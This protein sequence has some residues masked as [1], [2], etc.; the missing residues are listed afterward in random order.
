MNAQTDEDE[1]DED[2]SG[3]EWPAVQTNRK[4]SGRFVLIKRS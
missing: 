1:D 2:G 4:F 3:S